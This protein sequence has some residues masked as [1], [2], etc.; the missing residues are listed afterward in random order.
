MKYLPLIK[1]TKAQHA[2]L[3]WAADPMTQFW[4][5]K[6]EREDEGYTVVEDPIILTPAGCQVADH[7]GVLADLKYRLLEQYPCLLDDMSAL[8]SIN[9]QVA[10]ENAWT[11]IWAV[12]VAAGHGRVLAPH[13]N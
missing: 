13:T 6:E 10:S 1:L 3:E 2:V 12:A 9:R 5:D 7:E 8:E 4:L 11:K